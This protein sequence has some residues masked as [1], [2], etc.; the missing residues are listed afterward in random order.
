MNAGFIHKY[1]HRYK[2]VLLALGTLAMV[3]AIHNILLL[4]FQTMKARSAWDSTTIILEL[5]YGSLCLNASRGY[6][7]ITD[8]G[9]VLKDYWGKANI[10]WTQIEKYDP[11]RH[12][13]IL[14][15]QLMEQQIKRLLPKIF[16]PEREFSLSSFCSRE[17]C[18]DIIFFTKNSEQNPIT[19]NDAR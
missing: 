13:I 19:P 2:Y 14:K 11:I 1:Q 16:V 15:T 4:I 9:V 17:D 3:L 10:L 8:Q 18:A 6:L 12:R 5:I 7:L